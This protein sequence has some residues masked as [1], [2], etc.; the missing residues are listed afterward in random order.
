M[1]LIHTKRLS[2]LQC[3][4]CQITFP[5]QDELRSHTETV[6]CS[7]RC[8]EC[9]EEFESK[10]LRLE[11]QRSHHAENESEAL[12]MDLDDKKWNR[13]KDERKE[14]KTYSDDL[15]KSRCEPKVEMENWITANITLF[16]AGR[17]EK[18]KARSRTELGHWYITYMA[19]AT[20]NKIVQHPCKPISTLKGLRLLT[21]CS[22]RLCNHTALRNGRREDFTHI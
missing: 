19:L 21:L 15:K 6:D 17:Q 1:K 2:T 3:G 16:E 8:L 5:D 14:F 12:F 20:E 18:A 9:D 10:A 22:L 13:I 7:P 4:V 11:H